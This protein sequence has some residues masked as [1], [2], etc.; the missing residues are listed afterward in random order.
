[1]N[2]LALFALIASFAVV[3][4][5]DSGGASPDAQPD[6]DTATAVPDADAA[7][8][9]DDAPDVD[10]EPPHPATR[11]ERGLS[12]VR[13][14]I[15]LHSGFSHDA[16]DEAFEK[17]GEAELPWSC[18][19]RMKAAL[20]REQIAVAFMTDHPSFMRDQ[21]FA[22]LLYAE[23]E[24]GDIVLTEGD[25]TPWGVSFQCPE[26]Q[27]ALD[28]RMILVVGFEGPHTMPIG[29]RKHLEDHSLYGIRF[30]DSTPPADLDALTAGVRAAGGRVTIAHSEETDLSWQTIADHDVPAMELYNFHANF[31]QVLNEGDLFGALS[32]LDA[33]IDDSPGAPE[34]DLAGLAMLGT[35]PE[36]A[37]EKWRRVSVARP[38]TAIAGSDVHENVLL[39]ALGPSI[40]LDELALDAPHV[41]KALEVGGPLLMGDGERLDAYE[42]IFR[43]VQNRVLIDGEADPL[44]AVEAGIDAGR[45][46]VVF[47]L[48]GNAVGVDLLAELQDGTLREMG[49]TVPA[50]STLWVRSPDA[51]VPG[52]NARWTDGS[53]AELHASVIRTTAEGSETVATLDGPGQWRSLPLDAPGSYHLEVTLRP[54]HLAASLGPRDDLAGFTYRWVETNAIRVEP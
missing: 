47:E 12:E 17:S 14:I 18:V 20:C 38:I 48:L 40:I 51:P 46:I 37:L 44:A 53:A 36:A 6:A 2:R 10:I 28:G 1:M 32:T 43:W 35:Y 16:C 4:C 45:L 29:L 49:S 11:A 54:L 41:A 22:D 7:D 8:A 24:A 21:P 25:G 42:R 5:D 34:A 39:P 52:R 31:N 9:V 3:A 30:S 33:F 23:P 15:H 26:G 13:A 27:G 19:H 50:G